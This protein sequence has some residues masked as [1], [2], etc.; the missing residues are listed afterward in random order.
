MSSQSFM[1][2]GFN[3]AAKNNNRSGANLSQSTYIPDDQALKAM[4]TRISSG[5]S[6]PFY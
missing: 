6:N 2:T 4:N 5:K 1:G 3:R